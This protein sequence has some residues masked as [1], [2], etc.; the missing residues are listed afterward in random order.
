VRFVVEGLISAAALD[1]RPA[2][3]LRW[4]LAQGR[5][6]A[7]RFRQQAQSS[8]IRPVNDPV[9][10]RPTS[11][12]SAGE[13]LTMPTWSVDGQVDEKTPRPSNRAERRLRD[14]QPGRN[15]ARPSGRL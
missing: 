10:S 15:K 3:W 6:R 7:N 5:V 9:P 12:S 2:E 8:P 1:T 11:K 14:K 13:P 4:L